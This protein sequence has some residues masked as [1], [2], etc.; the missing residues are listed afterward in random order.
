MQMRKIK[1][2]EVSLLG[3]GCMRF[4]VIEGTQEIDYDKTM[5]M[6]DLAIKEGITYF[7]TAY[8]YHNG[9]SEI[10]VG[11]LLKKYPRNSFVLASKMPSWMFKTLDEAKKIFEEQLVKCQ[12][13]YFDFYLCHAMNINHHETYLQLGV[14]DYLASMKK[15]GKI[16]HLGFSFHDAP[17]NIIPIADQLP[18]DFAQIQFNYL[19][20][21]MQ[22]AKLQY[23]E[24]TKRNISVV[25]MEP[26][27]GGMLANVCA[28]AE[29]LFK[30]KREKAS[31]ASWALRYVASFPNV[32]VILSGMSNLEQLQDNLHTFNNYEP[33]TDEEH[34]TLIEARKAIFGNNFIPCT[35]CRYCMPCPFGVDIPR[36]FS[37]YNNL[38]SIRKDLNAFKEAINKM[39]EN[40]RPNN[41]KK[42]GKCVS[43]CPQQIAI[44]K[45]LEIINNLL[46]D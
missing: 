21:E 17:Q 46:N 14:Y 31:N 29:S 3:M 43:H 45:Q 36:I 41:C 10:V 15:A 18:W 38:Y 2:Q 30:N 40:K 9:Q 19:D 11:K 25:V 5:A 23:E 6:F 13:E 37:L 22:D 26:V 12:V 20:Y 8:P 7:D 24:L 42:C 33:L 32:K 16:R 1:N 4:P 39:D 35:G 44:F 28:E 34:Q 27:R